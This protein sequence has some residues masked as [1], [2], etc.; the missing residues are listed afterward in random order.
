MLDRVEGQRILT[1]MAAPGEGARAAASPFERADVAGSYEDWCA[2]PYGRWAER[3]EHELVHGLLGPLPD[4]ARVLDL[5]CGTGRLA[6]HWSDRGWRAVG[7]DPSHTMLERAAR[8]LPVVRA[9][10]RRLPFADGAFDAVCATFVLEFAADPVAVL[11]EARRVARTRVVVL[12]LA[13][14]SWLGWRRR[15]QAVRGHPIFAHLRLHPRARL[16]DF[17][18]A[19]GAE[20]LEARGLLFLPP[21][22]VPRLRGIE[23]RLSCATLV[24]A[25]VV[26]FALAGAASKHAATG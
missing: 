6:G 24:G 13:R 20:P 14:D 7:L 21:A 5:G 25:G 3:V 18:R 2:T 11:R 9:D 22:L 15:M 17:A 1:P 19:A 10:G 16:F 8:R 26:G 12:A 23:R 4:G